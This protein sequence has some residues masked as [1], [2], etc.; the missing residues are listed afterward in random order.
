MC[1]IFAMCSMHAQQLNLNHS[2]GGGWATWNWFY[3]ISPLSAHSELVNIQLLIIRPERQRGSFFLSFH[4]SDLFIDIVH[5]IHVSRQPEGEKSMEKW[6]EIELR[7]Q[8]MMMKLLLQVLYCW[9][10]TTKFQLASH[11]ASLQSHKNI[12]L[13]AA[14]FVIVVVVFLPHYFIQFSLMTSLFRLH[15]PSNLSNSHHDSR[16]CLRALPCPSPNGN[17]ERPRYLAQ[18]TC[19]PLTSSTQSRIET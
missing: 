11:R 14:A 15:N 5:T 2:R 6:M 3:T 7:W 1:N 8:Q 19:M 18:F 16:L 13:I 17:S 4:F 12:S 10:N 9:I